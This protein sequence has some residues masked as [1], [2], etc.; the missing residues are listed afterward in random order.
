[1]T[2]PVLSFGNEALDNPFEPLRHVVD[3]INEP[4]TPRTV[5]LNSDSTCAKCLQVVPCSPFE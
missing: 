2:Y 3:G 1:M 5:N 4:V